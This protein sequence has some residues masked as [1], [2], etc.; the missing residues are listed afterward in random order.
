VAGLTSAVD[1]PTVHPY[2]SSLAGNYDVFVSKFTADG[3]NLVY[4]TFLGGLDD[5]SLG[6]IALGNGG[7]VFVIGTTE[8][9][10]FPTVAALQSTFG[11]GFEDAFVTRFSSTGSALY[12]TYL[13]GSSTDTGGGIAVDAAGNALVFGTASSSNFPTTGW[14]PAT[15]SSSPTGSVFVAMISPAGGA[16]VG[17]L[18]R[19]S[20]VLAALLALA[21]LVAM[22]DRFRARPAASL[23]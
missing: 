15:T 22:R 18:G 3:S 9:N 21:G 20:G 5:E 12:S 16:P 23:R 11:G 10:D 1:F 7:D 14:I 6:G 2:Q 13:G 17:A 19:F 4:S 8:S